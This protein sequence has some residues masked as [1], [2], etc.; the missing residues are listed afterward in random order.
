MEGE[1]LSGGPPTFRTEAQRTGEFEVRQMLFSLVGVGT[2]FWSELRVGR[3]KV[4]KSRR[5]DW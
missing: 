5:E 3:V 1:G 2:V 4:S